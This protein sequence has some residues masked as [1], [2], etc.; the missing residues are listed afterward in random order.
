MNLRCRRRLNFAFASMADTAEAP[1]IVHWG[2]SVL[3][4][5]LTIANVSLTRTNT[6][7]CLAASRVTLP[8]A[9]HHQTVVIQELCASK[10][11]AARIPLV[12]FSSLQTV[13]I[14]RVTRAWSHLPS[15]SQIKERL[16][17]FL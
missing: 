7:L 8:S 13:L 14:L 15:P 10:A 17:W 6:L 2:T 4:K 16:R 5:P 1:V 3:L 12:F 9:V 11:A